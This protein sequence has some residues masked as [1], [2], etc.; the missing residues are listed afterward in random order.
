[1]RLWFTLEMVTIQ[2][3]LFFPELNNEGV[4]E[5]PDDFTPE[6]ISTDIEVTEEMMDQSNEKRSEAMTALSDGKV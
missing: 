6:Q 4:V 2:V 1:M 5:D 3:I